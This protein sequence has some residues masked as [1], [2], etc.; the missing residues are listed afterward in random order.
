[1]KKHLLA[2]CALTLLAQTVH[3]FHQVSMEY[4]AYV[5]DAKDR[6]TDFVTSPASYEYVKV[7]IV[8]ISVDFH[9]MMHTAQLFAHK[10]GTYQFSSPDTQKQ[11]EEASSLTQMLGTLASWA[12]NAVSEPFTGMQPEASTPTRNQ[13]LGASRFVDISPTDNAIVNLKHLT[14]TNTLADFFIF[15]PKSSE[16]VQFDMEQMQQ[17]FPQLSNKQI[18]CRIPGSLPL[19]RSYRAEQ[20]QEKDDKSPEST[21]P[22]WHELSKAYEL[23]TGGIGG[24][25]L[26]YDTEM[27]VFQQQGSQRVKPKTRDHLETWLPSPPK[28]IIGLPGL[29]NQTAMSL[30]GRVTVTGWFPEWVATPGLYSTDYLLASSH[31]NLAGDGLDTHH[32]FVVYSAIQNPYLHEQSKLYSSQTT[33]WRLIVL[34]WGNKF[35]VVLLSRD[36]TSNKP[37]TVESAPEPNVDIDELKKA[38]DDIN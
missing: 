37:I 38:L 20:K 14:G 9:G 32:D 30:S 24:A 3:G 33:P 2:G 31:P 19:C 36:F 21:R 22:G 34:P 29:F 4:D 7:G 10:A 25:S 28:V 17:G 5:L 13:D 11:T 27:Y 35:Q 6:L 15:A 12:F 26:L 1:M 18:C 16:W 8:S 23:P